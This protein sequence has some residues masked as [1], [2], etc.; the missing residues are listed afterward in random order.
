MRDHDPTTGWFIQAD[1]LGLV[2]GANVDGIV[3]D[4]FL[5]GGIEKEDWLGDIG[6]GETYGIGYSRD[7]GVF[8]WNED[9]CC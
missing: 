8:L 7:N 9:Q 6:F 5:P 1:P 3:F 2:D 4:H